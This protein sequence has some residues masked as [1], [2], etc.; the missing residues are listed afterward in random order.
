MTEDIK[1][2]GELTDAEKGALLLAHQEGKQIEVLAFWREPGRWETTGK[3]VW[4]GC[5]KYRV[6]PEPV[7]ET[8]TLV[9][10]RHAFSLPE[11]RVKTDTHRIT[12]DLIDGEPDCSSISME[13]V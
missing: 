10:D 1:P 7:V 9:G 4:G 5:Y 13:P 6:K 12:F 8:V 3:P 2:W 11:L